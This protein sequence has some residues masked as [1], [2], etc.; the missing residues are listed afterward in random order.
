MFDIH[1][2]ILPGVDDGSGNLNDSI[3]MAQ[4]AAESGTKGIVATPHCNISGMFNNY[5]NAEFK[6]KFLHLKHAL[7]QKSI[8]VEV[9]SGQEVFLSSHFEE[10][11]E[12]GEL[13]T[14]NGS[15]YMLVELDFKID[16]ADAF[17]RLERLISYGCIPV[18]AHPE[19]YGFVIENPDV[20]RKIRSVGAFAQ[21]NSCSLTG[22]FGH[23]IQETANIIVRNRFADFVASD[24]HSQYSR[25]P[26]L[27]QVHELICEN[28]SYDYADVLFKINPVKLLNN[29][30]I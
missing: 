18:V 23:L 22:E 14:L 15:R 10:H 20:I 27:A 5:Y 1:C 21:V 24:A 17:S 12:K 26:S 25:T 6:E 2:H 28:F 11:L 30:T 7:Q 9:Y 16:A 13:I 3:E 19:R 8:P 4:L 29:E